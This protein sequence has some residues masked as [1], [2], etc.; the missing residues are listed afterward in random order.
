MAQ[1]ARGR[2][3]AVNMADIRLSLK[4]GASP[5][6]NMP[7]LYLF[8]G[9]LERKASGQDFRMAKYIAH[10]ATGACAPCRLKS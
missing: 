6:S 10:Q 3:C 1:G 9:T 8:S 7:S 4:H 2:N 5:V